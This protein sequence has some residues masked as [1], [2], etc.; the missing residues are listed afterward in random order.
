MSKP[1]GE[2]AATLKRLAAGDHL[3]AAESAGSF[4]NRLNGYTYV[5]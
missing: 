3:S 4:A 2:F 1:D 5:V